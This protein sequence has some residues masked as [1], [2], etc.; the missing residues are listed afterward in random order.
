MFL[1]PPSKHVYVE[2]RN[3]PVPTALCSE[4]M[5]LLDRSDFPVAVAF[6]SYAA[7]NPDLPLHPHCFIPLFI[8]PSSPP[9]IR[10]KERHWIMC[11]HLHIVVICLFSQAVWVRLMA[12][13]AFFCFCYVWKRFHGSEIQEALLQSWRNSV[14]FVKSSLDATRGTLPERNQFHEGHRKYF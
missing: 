4:F 12:A 8:Y 2:A 3:C 1:K 14:N 7:N 6:L 13:M 10:V 5:G 11:I 9:P